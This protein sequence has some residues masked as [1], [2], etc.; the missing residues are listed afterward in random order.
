MPPQ[1]LSLAFF[2]LEEAIKVTPAIAAEIQQMFNKGVPTDQDWAALRA[3]V[4]GK[5]YRDYVPDSA[6]PPSETEA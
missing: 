6:L 2:V 4:A 5:T 1:A 3:K